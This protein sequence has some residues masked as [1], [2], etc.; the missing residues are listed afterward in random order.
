MDAGA[1]RPGRRRHRRGRRHRPGP[2]R[3]A[4][5]RGH[6]G[7]RGRRAAPTLV[8]ATAA[9][10]GERGEVL[11][12]VTDVS[13][14]TSVEALAD[15]TYE[16]FGACHLLVNNA[17]VGAPSAHVVGDHPQRLALGPRRQ[18]HGRGPR[19]PR[20]RAPDDRR[21]ASRATWSTPPRATAASSRCRAPRST[22]SSKAAVT[23]LTE[24]LASSCESRG[25]ERCGRRSSTRPA[26]CCGPGCGSPSAPAPPSWPASGPAP[27]SR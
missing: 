1:D 26:A 16:R 14:P 15:A 19:R 27:P 13:D 18:R 8:A 22:P 10:L 5:G 2:G 17:G 3:G 6:E 20:L 21:R 25:H 9:E 11:G 4:A 12:V 24:C 23:T 7:R